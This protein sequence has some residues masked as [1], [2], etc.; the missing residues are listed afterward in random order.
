M[1]GRLAAWL[2]LIGAQILLGY[3]SRATQGKP[4]RDLVYH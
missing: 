3:A 1:S 4:D 2:A